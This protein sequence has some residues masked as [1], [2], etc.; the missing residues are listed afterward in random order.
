[1]SLL[2]NRLRVNQQRQQ[3]QEY[4]EYQPTEEELEAYYYQ[5]QMEEQQRQQEQEEAERLEDASKAPIAILEEIRK[6]PSPKG[7]LPVIIGG[8][9]I[10]LHV[11]EDYI[12]KISPH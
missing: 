1:M 5:Q 6:H 3:Q 10:D 4:E 11:L 8:R 12:V 7:T 2:N 9:P